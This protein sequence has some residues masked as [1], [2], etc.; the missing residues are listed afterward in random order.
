MSFMDKLKAGA[1]EAATKAKEATSQAQSKME[2]SQ[3]RKKI[4]ENAKQLGYLIFRERTQGTPAG[5]E[6]DQ[7]VTD[8]QALEAQ[9]A[10]EAAS[11]AAPQAVAPAEGQ[12]AAAPPPSTSASE[13][14]SGD[15]KL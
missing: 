8:M 10:A 14:T 9:L 15:F 4:D 2:Q 11:S 3:I 6:A 12:E 1:Q 7:L 13:P 5:S